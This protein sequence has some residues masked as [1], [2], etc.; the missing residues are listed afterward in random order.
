METTI[1]QHPMIRQVAVLGQGR[2]CIAALIEVD[3]D[4]A[5]QFGPEDIIAGVHAAVKEANKEC[6]S[7]ST[8]LPQMVKILPLNQTLPLTDMGTVM[9]KKA[10][11]QYK[12][13]VDQM[14]KDFIEGPSRDT[15]DENTGTSTWSAK[16]TEE[17]L[18]TAAA[19]VLN[20]PKSTFKDRSQ[21]DFDHGLNSLNS[22]QL[23]NSISQYFDNIP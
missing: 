23:G 6:P 13:L 20:V 9:R 18:I 12:D 1:R 16:D 7:H 10:A 2:Q 3:M 11:F 15:T 14:Y 19:E 17:F 8:I 21:S 22:I 4:Y 5:V